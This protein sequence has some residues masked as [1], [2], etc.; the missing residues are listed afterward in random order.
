MQFAENAKKLAQKCF[1]GEVKV[2]KT[3]L[4]LLGALCLLIGIV[5]GL[6]VAPITHG[7]SVGCGCGNNYMMPTEKEEEE[8]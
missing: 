3:V 5:Y 6:L 1:V 8:E 4:W 7:I 2:A